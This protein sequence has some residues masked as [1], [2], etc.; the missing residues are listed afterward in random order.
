M[1]SSQEKKLF[2]LMVEITADAKSL[3]EKMETFYQ[4][5]DRIGRPSEE[6]AAKL[7]KKYRVEFD[8]FEETLGKLT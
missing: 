8:D 2:G 6:E 4:Y 5:A 3:I 7:Y 1:T